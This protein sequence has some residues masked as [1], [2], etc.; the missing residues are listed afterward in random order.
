[1]RAPIARI[2]A[3]TTCLGFGAAVLAQGLNSNMQQIE[4]EFS[5]LVNDKNQEMAQAQQALRDC[6]TQDA[7]A[8]N[9]IA[10]QQADAQNQARQQQ[11][12]NLVGANQA[13]PLSGANGLGGG[14][15]PGD[16]G[17]V[18][19]GITGNGARATKMANQELGQIKNAVTSRNA[20]IATVR[21]Q[22]SSVAPKLVESP[23]HSKEEVAS[24]VEQ[25]KK[26]PNFPS[27]YKRYSTSEVPQVV[28]NDVKKLSDLQQRPLFTYSEGSGVVLDQSLARQLCSIPA[29]NQEYAMNQAPVNSQFYVA[30]TPANA[31]T[32]GLRQEAS[33]LNTRY[34]RAM[35]NR[36]NGTNLGSELMKAGLNSVARSLGAKAAAKNNPAHA[37][38][39]GP[40]GQPDGIPDMSQY[41]N[42]NADLQRQMCEQAARDQMD[43]VKKAISDLNARR[44]RALMNAQLMGDASGQK[45]LGAPSLGSGENGDGTAG[46]VV[47][48]GAPS[49]LTPAGAKGLAAAPGAEGGGSPGAAAAGGGA[50]AGG[51]GNADWT[52]GA[53]GPPGVP[54]SG[55][56]EQPSFDVAGG[57]GGGGGYGAFG[58][59]PEAF[60]GVDPFADPNGYGAT[61]TGA[62]GEG[63]GDGGLL[64]VLARA[65]MRLADHADQLV[66]RM[67]LDKMAANPI[68]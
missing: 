13:N 46:G 55:P 54:A 50:G 28:L 26:D 4:D 31:C 38:N 47:N 52:F 22:L 11:L 36:S 39:T 12:D 60:G 32:T 63:I 20:E 44:A 33:D 57:G 8:R 48:A 58:G 7:A 6:A 45:G 25:L 68:R 24:Y 42:Q 16:I 66:R 41:A 19:N 3:Y 1:M 5:N 43:A 14:G 59:G 56:M 9:E 35:D 10:Q 53:G 18:I 2:I 51:G 27:D 49:S 15:L 17:N 61:G 67:P 21:D 23:T 62:A 29:F 65:R 30:Q 34:S 64:V 37:D 40:N